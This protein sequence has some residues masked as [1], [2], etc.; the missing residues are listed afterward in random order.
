MSC[1]P[2]Y[3]WQAWLEATFPGYT[4]ASESGTADSIAN[5]P[6][7]KNATDRAGPAIQALNEKATPAVRAINEKAAP[8]MRAINEKA[9]AA[10]TAIQDNE[11]IQGVK[12]RATDGLETVKAK[13]RGIDA[14][15]GISS[16]ASASVGELMTPARKF[17][18]PDGQIIEKPDEDEVQAGDKPAGSVKKLNIKNTAIKFSLDQT[19]GAVV[20]NVLFITSIGAL[21]GE[22]SGQIITD[23]RTV[24][25]S[26]R[27]GCWQC[28]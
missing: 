2:N 1:P 9:S 25:P 14:R 10:S 11:V 19:F 7:V 17:S 12:R 22:P 26:S 13:A 23:V 18:T 6:T 20:N 4:P 21:R 16:K 27:M 24:S 3:L 28:S 8:A 15:T 5:H